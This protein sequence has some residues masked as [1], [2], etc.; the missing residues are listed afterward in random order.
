[1]EGSVRE[2]EREV[3]VELAYVSLCLSL[4]LFDCYYFFVVVVIVVNV[5]QQSLSRFL[6]FEKM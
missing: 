4:S 1:M 5:T 6:R 2:K 3:G